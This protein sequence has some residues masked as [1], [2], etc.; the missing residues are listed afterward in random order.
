LRKKKDSRTKE[1]LTKEE[2]E[3]IEKANV[4][5]FMP[6]GIHHD[7]TSYFDDEGNRFFKH[8]SI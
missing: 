3:Q 7:G 4:G 8:P 2:I 5:E 6:E 1:S